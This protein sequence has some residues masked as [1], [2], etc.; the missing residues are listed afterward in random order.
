MKRALPH[1]MLILFAAIIMI[2]FVYMALASIKT[3][4]GNASG[5]FLPFDDHGRILWDTFTLQNYADLFHRENVPSQ[6]VNSFFF[7]SVTSLLATLI[8]AMGGYALAM[9]NF[10]GRQLLTSFVLAALVIPATL[11][12]APA[13]QLVYRFGLLDTLAGLILPA[14]APAFLVFLFRQAMLSS[15]PME[16]LEAG[17][18]DG[19]GEIRMFFTIA[20]PLVRPMVSASLLITFIGSWN[21]F[22]SPQVILQSPQNFTLSVAVAQLKDVYAQNYG[23]LMAGT[24]V[25]VLPVMILFLLLQKEFISGLTSG[26]VKG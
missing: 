13:Y 14:I 10:K 4:T 3:T 22:I 2:P 20:L 17:R 1:V 25:S 15:L 9:F 23:M 18:I 24:V 7:A 5:L 26:A 6:I 21:N 8:C 19:C 16:L 12:I 11:L